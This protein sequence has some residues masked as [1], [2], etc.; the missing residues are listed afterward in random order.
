MTLAAD[1]L[2]EQLRDAGCV[3]A[4]DEARL[5]LDASAG[6]GDDLRA[7]LE[8]R[9]AGEPLE[10]VVG[11]AE[12]RGAR[13]AVGPGVFVPR[14]RTEA[15]VA[16]ALELVRDV[17]RPIVVDLCCGSGAL[18]ATI[19]R[20]LIDVQLHASDV[21]PVAIEYARRNVQPHGGAVYVG[22]MDA[23]L[24]PALRGRVDLLVANVPYV[25]TC[26]IEL[27]PRE[28]REH[29][30]RHTFDG[31]E[32]GLDLARGIAELA[33]AWLTSGG[34]VLV[35]VTSAQAQMLTGVFEWAG[36]A[37]T[38]VTD[39]ELDATILVGTRHR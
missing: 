11:W 20:E 32:D 36:L 31:G 13:I 33:P 29:E 27:L 26:D 8:R 7:M 23:A 15:L 17:S 19:A 39:D 30:P 12:F 35:E 16:H 4:E 6:S 28:A 5:L 38:I 18:G 9:L 10:H 34:H 24:P 3:F 14:P 25:P 21:D 22:D 1:P 37:A 2:V